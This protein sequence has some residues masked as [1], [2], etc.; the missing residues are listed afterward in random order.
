MLL[1][2]LP[3]LLD[4]L[5]HNKYR[6]VT[7]QKRTLLYG[8][9]FLIFL[10]LTSC[11]IPSL[12]LF[13]VPLFCETSSTISVLVTR[14]PRARQS[15]TSLVQTILTSLFSTCLL[16]ISVLFRFWIV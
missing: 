2:N 3:V 9:L 12:S 16:H 7:Y 15:I 1:V 5:F 14:C 11:L 6:Y 8:I 4:L 10:L 13:L